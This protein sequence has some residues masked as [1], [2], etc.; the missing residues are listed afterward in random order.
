[1]LTK[2]KTRSPIDLIIIPTCIK[3]TTEINGVIATCSTGTIIEIED[4]ISELGVES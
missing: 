3:L 4:R 2:I 1:M